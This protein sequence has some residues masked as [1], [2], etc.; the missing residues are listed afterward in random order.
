MTNRK[1]FRNVFVLSVITIILLPDVS[2]DRSLS[3]EKRK[4]AQMAQMN[5]DLILGGLFPM[6]EHNASR[7]EQP[8]GAIKEE[9]GIQVLYCITFVLKLPYLSRCPYLNLSFLQEPWPVRFTTAYA[10]VNQLFKI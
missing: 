10:F 2:S 6:H 9:K 8:C 7:M 1:I 4:M 5:G 3:S